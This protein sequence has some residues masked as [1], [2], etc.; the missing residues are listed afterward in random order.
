MSMTAIEEI[1]IVVLRARR[2]GQ[3]ALRLCKTISKFRGL[4]PG[5]RAKTLQ[6][7]GWLETG[8]MLTKPSWVKKA[9][10]DE[11][12]P[13]LEHLCRNKKDH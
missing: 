10:L 4:D 1:R 5:R 7:I 6:Q 12:M 3:R 8:I 13:V 11:L 9:S 2:R